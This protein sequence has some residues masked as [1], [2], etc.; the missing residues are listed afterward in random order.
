M[1]A[2]YTKP[3]LPE[4]EGCAIEFRQSFVGGLKTAVLMFQTAEAASEFIFAEED[5]EAFQA[6]A[7]EQ[8]IDHLIFV[9][10]D[11]TCGL[12]LVKPQLVKGRGR[13]LTLSPAEPFYEP[14]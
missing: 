10:P 11:Q 3:T 13:R 14:F 8:A 4:I 1:Q 5:Y 7:M 9:A 12:H 2:T 6:R